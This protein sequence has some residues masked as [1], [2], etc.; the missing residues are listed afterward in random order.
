ML[1]IFML[2][3]YTSQEYL[4]REAL[5]LNQ[6]YLPIS[7]MPPKPVRIF[8]SIPTSTGG[9]GEKQDRG[10]GNDEDEKDSLPLAIRK[11]NLIL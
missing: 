6:N 9:R 5:H 7:N 8:T 10:A 11:S 3:L 1:T 4:I 2:L